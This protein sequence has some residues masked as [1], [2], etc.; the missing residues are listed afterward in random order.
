MKMVRMSDSWNKGT[1]E[2]VKQS[3]SYALTQECT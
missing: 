3:A 1:P 2:S